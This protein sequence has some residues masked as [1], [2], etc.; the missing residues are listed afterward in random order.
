MAGGPLSTDLVKIQLHIWQTIWKL[1]YMIYLSLLQVV[2]RQLW[3]L[4]LLQNV[5]H[6][7]IAHC[8]CS[9]HHWKKAVT[10][11]TQEKHLLPSRPEGH[12][13][14][15]CVW[16]VFHEVGIHH[17]IEG[18]QISSLYLWNKLCTRLGELPWHNYIGVYP[19]N[20]CCPTEKSYCVANI[21]YICTR[22]TPI[23]LPS[24]VE[25]LPYLCM[26]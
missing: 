15:K 17:C 1:Y 3:L 12:I 19:I 9:S 8:V 11:Y 4:S 6:Y 24:L 13:L 22:W 2:E 23:S 18:S 21:L 16:F 7:T 10:T 25:E 20:C 26:I 5:H 14:R